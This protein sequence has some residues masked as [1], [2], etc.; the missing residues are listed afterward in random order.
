VALAVLLIPGFSMRSF[1]VA[2]I[3][4]PHRI[5]Q[6][7]S[8][9]EDTEV[10]PAQVEKYVAVYRAMQRDRS[11]TVEAAAAE[12]GMTLFAFRQLE[13]RVER[14][15]VALQRARRELQASALHSSPPASP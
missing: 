6:A 2:D 13:S 9:N 8:S 12:N 5:V 1:A 4:N 3:V 15:E 14:D 7:A 10:P 11:L